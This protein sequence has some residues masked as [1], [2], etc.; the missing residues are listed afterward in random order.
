MLDNMT[1]K[2]NYTDHRYVK[3][4]DSRTDK[5]MEPL[6]R[7][8]TDLVAQLKLLTGSGHSSTMVPHTKVNSRINQRQM[9]FHYGHWQHANG[10]YHK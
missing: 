5:V 7:L 10:N 9:G 1:Q 4:S 8:F 3:K 6:T 2:G